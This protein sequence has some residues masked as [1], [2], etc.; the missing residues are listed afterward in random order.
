MA[1]SRA[2]NRAVALGERGYVLLTTMWLLLLAGSI[3]GLMLLTTVERSR[4]TKEYMDEAEAVH[5]LDSALATAV[6]DRLFASQ[7]AQGG[8]ASQQIDMEG[9]VV[10]VQ[11]SSETSRIDLNTANAEIVGQAIRERGHMWSMGP[12]ENQALIVAIL[13]RR[14]EG[15]TFRSAVEVAQIAQGDLD[16]DTDYIFTIATR[17]RGPS[18]R[19]LPGIGVGAAAQSI[20]RGH[21]A[22]RFRATLEGYAGQRSR[23]I[24]GRMSSIRGKTFSTIDR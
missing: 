10:S 11:T 19:Q 12:T 17:A 8:G 22:V 24:V 3:A 5:A 7:T 1:L 6:A 20:N 13:A 16:G 21:A 14:V 23:T 18:S 4:S 2:Q 15:M 9:V